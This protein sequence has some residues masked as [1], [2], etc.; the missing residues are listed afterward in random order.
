MQDPIINRRTPPIAFALLGAVTAT[1][2]VSAALCP[3]SPFEY[4]NAQ[5][6]SLPG[7]SG[8]LADSTEGGSVNAQADRLVSEDGLVILEGNTTIEY[9]GRKMSAENALYNPLTGELSIDGTLSF[10]GQ[11]IELQ[12]N[13]AYFDIDDDLFRTGPSQ[14]QLQL[15]DKHASGDAISMEGLPNGDFNL[16]QATYSACPPQDKSWYVKAE[17]LTLYP[18]EGVGTAR[19]IRLVFKGV[20]LLALPVFSFPISDAR[21]TGFL[22]PILARGESTGFELHLPWYWNIRPNLDATFT[23]RFMSRRGTQLHSEFR[24]M[25]SQGFWQLDHEYLRDRQLNGQTRYF[26]QLT[27]SGRFNPNV[28]STV[29]ARR[30]SDKDYLEDLGDGLQLASI[31]HLERRADLNYQQANVRALARLQ[32]FQTVDEDISADDRP[33]SR[34]PQLKL[35]THSEQWPLGLRGEFTGEFVYFDKDDAVTGA[36]VDMHPGLSWPIVRDAWFV[37]PSV[38]HRFTYYNLNNTGETILDK[39]SSRNVNSLSVDS[40]L[41]F[42]RVLDDTGTILTLEPRV[43]YLNVPFTDQSDIPIF[44]SSAFDFNISQLFRGNRFSGADRIA[45]ANQ[46]SMALTTRLIDGT[47]GSERFRASIGQI[48]YFEDRRVTLPEDD[49][50]AAQNQIDTRNL[51]DFVGE[52]S[53]TVRDHWIGRGSIQWNPDEERTVRSSL[54]FGYRGDASQIA[55]VTHRVVNS[56]T[57]EDKT[58]QIDLSALWGIGQ[59]WRIAA[60]WNFSLDADRSIESLLGLEYDSCCWALR[61][62]ARR[63]ISD[64]G[65]DHDTSVYLQLVLKGLAPLGQNYGALLENSILG[66]TDSTDE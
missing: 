61:F 17:S 7:E 55:N 43:F 36:R 23:P 21:K 51:S 57:R 26:T 28:T 40:G 65:D 29:V 15:D 8:Q 62:A 35:H 42:D 46:L 38:S 2:D 20:P 52:I 13:D 33:H 1:T 34:L 56:D 31:T 64:D 22:A 24:Y 39:T 10:T 66:Y 32:G 11:G 19:N 60:R 59:N 63:Y 12:S 41:F 5:I 27:H 45:D 50:A 16:D 4:T 44:D 37:T 25:N 58:E 53:A 6:A 9:R 48:Q 49:T 18:E 54:S 47:R 30:I 3:A 14:Y